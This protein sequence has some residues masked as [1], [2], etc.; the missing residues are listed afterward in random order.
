VKLIDSQCELNTI[1][2]LKSNLIKKKLKK[3][4]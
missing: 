2:K 1:V 4:C 3:E